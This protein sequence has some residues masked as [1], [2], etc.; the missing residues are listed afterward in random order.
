MLSVNYHL[1]RWDLLRRAILLVAWNGGDGCRI[2]S[3]RQ[4]VYLAAVV[5][6]C[7]GQLAFLKGLIITLQLGAVVGKA[8]WIPLAVWTAGSC[9]VY[10]DSQQLLK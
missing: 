5:P 7:C 4:E 6:G 8:V 2:T 10:L 3:C 9:G 1:R